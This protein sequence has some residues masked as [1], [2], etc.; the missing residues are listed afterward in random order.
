LLSGLFS[1]AVMPFGLGMTA[2]FVEQAGME[3]AEIRYCMKRLPKTPAASFAAA[4]LFLSQ[5]CATAHP[6]HYHPPGEDDEFDA[7]RADWLHVHGWFEIS[8]AL[9]ALAA[10]VVFR[11][12]PRRGV[13]IG[14]ALA[15]G[16]SLALIAAF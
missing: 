1:A 13:R 15:F 4:L 2:Y 6:G 10:V 9:L 16:G 3:P 11:M 7:F 14:A 12:N 8:L 5:L